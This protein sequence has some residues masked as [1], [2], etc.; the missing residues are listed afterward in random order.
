MDFSN[1]DFSKFNLIK[2]LDKLDQQDDKYAWIHI[3]CLVI[4]L[5]IIFGII[6]KIIL[7]ILK[8]FFNIIFCCCRGSDDDE[9][10]KKPLIKP[11]YERG[12]D[13][14]SGKKDLDVQDFSPSLSSPKKNKKKK[15]KNNSNKSSPKMT[16]DY[17][18]ST[19]N[20]NVMDQIEYYNPETP[21]YP[22]YPPM[23]Y[24]KQN[25]DTKGGQPPKQDDWLKMV[26]A[27]FVE[28]NKSKGIVV[29]VNFPYSER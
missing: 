29:R 2:L 25:Y 8:W 14:K 3:L 15:K 16:R 11:P 12:T 27:V 10:E 6:R 18:Y 13:E 23:K 1:I 28:T 22:Y 7:T 5:L 19:L 21:G 4:P 17:I 24:W 9:E 26:K 20:D